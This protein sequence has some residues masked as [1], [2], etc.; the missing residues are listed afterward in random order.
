MFHAEPDGVFLAYDA[1]N[2]NELWRFQTGEVGLGGA[3]GP[4]ASAAMT[5]ESAGE[6]F[7]ALANNR[8]VWAFKIGGT[9]PP[10]PAP[11]PPATV[12]EWTGRIE[13]TSDFQLG[14]VRTFNIASANKRVEWLNDYDLSPSRARIKA[15]ASITFRNIS[16]M[17]H[18]IEAR[19]RSWRVGA[20]AAG[21]AG[22]VTITRPGTYEYICTDHPWTIG[23]LIVE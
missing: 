21:A 9:V 3:A 19:D 17:S 7:V 23:Q 8:A 6:Q 18:T 11:P 10:R 20:I 2:G 4:S 12:R 5:Y 14:T 1:K 15:G 13:G 16:T 22:S